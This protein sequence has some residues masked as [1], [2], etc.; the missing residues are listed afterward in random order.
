M[1]ITHQKYL[2]KKFFENLDGIR[3]LSIIAVIWHHSAAHLGKYNLNLLQQG[4]HGVTLFFVLSGYLITTLL[5]REKKR[6]STINLKNF[7][8]RRTLRIFPLYYFVILFLYVPAVYFFE[9]NPARQSDFWNNLPY[10]LTYTGNIFATSTTTS[11]IFLF[12]WSL[13]IE[14]QFYIVWPTIEKYLSSKYTMILTLI[15]IAV[16]TIFNTH[17]SEMKHFTGVIIRLISVPIL[18][19]VISAHLLNNKKAYNIIHRVLGNK[20]SFLISAFSLLI[21]LELNRDTSFAI[22]FFA[23]TMVVSSVINSNFWG[24]NLMQSKVLVEIGKVSYGIYLYHVLTIN[25]IKKIASYFELHNGVIIFI[26]SCV[27]SY[28]ISYLSF[29]LFEIKFIKMKKNFSS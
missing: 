28:I 5:L 14:E 9:S 24:K 7:Y 12:S 8:A 21:S 23:T 6:T 25:M 17:I 13:A 11:M 10:F 1:D 19:G 3:A 29:N 18:M 22:Y 26:S 16:L 15:I 27:V 20:Y 4:N 2:E